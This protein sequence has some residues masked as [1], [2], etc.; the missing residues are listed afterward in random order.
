MKTLIA[1]LVA[2][3]LSSCTTTDFQNV[4]NSPQVQALITQAEQFAIQFAENWI[5]SHIGASRSLKSTGMQSGIQQCKAQ[6]VSQ[7]HLPDNVAGDIATASF[8]RAAK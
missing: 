8:A 3:V 5:T 2:A 6:L 7:Y 1:I 4:I